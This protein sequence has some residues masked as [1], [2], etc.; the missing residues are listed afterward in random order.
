MRMRVA[1]ARRHAENN[2][3]EHG[4]LNILT[5][6]APPLP[7]KRINGANGGK[8][9]FSNVK[10][11]PFR[12]TPNLFSRYRSERLVSIRLKNG[13]IHDFVFARRRI[14]GFDR[15][16]NQLPSSPIGMHRIRVF[17]IRKKTI[18]TV[19]RYWLPFRVFTLQ[20]TP[21]V[22]LFV[23]IVV[24]YLYF[25]RNELLVGLY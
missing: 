21:F 9:F 7:C 12:F 16:N 19:S 15:V 13:I 11:V 24:K 20:I 23:S 8:K 25:A 6:S 10:N 5:G 1:A 22:P 2:S 18:S 14:R 4:F 17:D 3:S